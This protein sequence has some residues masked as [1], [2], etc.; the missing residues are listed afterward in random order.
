MSAVDTARLADPAYRVETEFG[1]FYHHPEFPTKHNANQLYRC[2]VSKDDVARLLARV[3]ALYG[4]TGLDFRKISG[5]D[6]A[7]FETLRGP[8]SQRGW[9]LDVTW[10]MV[11]DRAPQRPVNPSIEVRA[12]DAALESIPDLDRLHTLE[13][14]TVDPLYL[15]DRAQDALV[16]GEW[17]IG[18]LEGEPVS[19]TGWYVV[20]GVARFRGVITVPEAQGQGAA[21]TLIRH[22][23]DHPTVRE[24][25]AL[26]IFCGEDGPVRLYEQL[27]FTKRATMWAFFKSLESG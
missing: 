18:Y 13:D 20:G 10:M 15:F 12:F 9:S 2:H 23:Q 22:V 21:T 4:P 27:G 25:D 16:G 8:L 1:P 19:H 3:E 24:Q 6:R 26:V 5:H 11:F 14:G 7:T 17:F